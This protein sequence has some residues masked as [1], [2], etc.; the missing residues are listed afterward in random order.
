MPTPAEQKALAF[1]ALVVL[2][3]GVV[4]VVRGGVLAPAAPTPPTP[5]EQ[6]AI[7]RQAFAASSSA[8]GQAATKDGKTRKSRKL[9]RSS[10]DGVATSTAI[11]GQP[12]GL[13]PRGFPPPG[14]RID[15]NGWAQQPALGPVAIPRKRPDPGLPAGPV[16][17]DTATEPE[18]EALPRVG[19]A[20]ARRIVA[21]RDSLGPFGS[22][23]ALRR[24]RGIG[25][26]TLELLT[27]L[28]TFSGQK[29]R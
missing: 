21:N 20:L 11:R 22:I 4:R 1:V 5:A 6:Q 14:P 19:P 8:A 3:G 29:R 24:V 2:L 18:I 26:A 27:P 9:A 16:D 7:A 15:M 13:D 25:P 17:L 10:G 12:S 23:Q 28:V